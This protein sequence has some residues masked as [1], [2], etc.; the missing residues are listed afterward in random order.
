MWRRLLSR[1]HPDAGGDHDLFIWADALRDHVAGDA[2]EPAIHQHPRRTTTAT[3]SRVPYPESTSDFDAI[4]RRALRR[5]ESV[6]G[7]YAWLLEL[8][9]D[10]YPSHSGRLLSEQRYGASYKRLAAIGHMTGM[11][12]AARSRWYRIAEDIPLSDRHASHILDR[13]GGT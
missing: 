8:L 4:T 2:P 11:D 10:C 1:C 13:L 5:A 6:P 7:A 9:V 12:K 3:S